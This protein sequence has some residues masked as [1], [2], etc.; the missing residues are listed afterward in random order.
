[1]KIKLLG[2]LLLFGVMGTA[3]A[4]TY[5]D[6]HNTNQYMRGSLFGA[7]DRYS[8]TFDITNDGYTP[9]AEYV[10]SASVRLHFRDDSRS[11][12][13]GF[14]WGHIEIG[15]VS[16]STFEIDSGSRVFNVLATATLSTL[17]ILNMT[18]EAD[19]G[20]FY[21]RGGT[22]TAQAA[23]YPAAVPAPSALLL[24]GSGLIG[25]ATAARRK[26]KA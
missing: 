7:D 13:D 10:T 5:T 12:W 17:G 2:I 23:S 18:V 4:A 26:I 19:L 25:I 14:E 16:T 21:F 20:D 24:M 15:G 22:L 8:W 11:F 6:T 9:G 3:S 1:M